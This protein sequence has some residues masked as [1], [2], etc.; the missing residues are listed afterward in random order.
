MY[1]CCFAVF[2]WNIVWSCGS[3]VHSS[4]WAANANAGQHYAARFTTKQQECFIFAS[5]IQRKHMEING[6]IWRNIFN[7]GQ[8]TEKIGK[9]CVCVTDIYKRHGSFQALGMKRPQS[10]NL[11]K[12]LTHVRNPCKRERK[13][14]ALKK[15]KSPATFASTALTF[16]QGLDFC[17]DLHSARARQLHPSRHQGSALCMQ[18]HDWGPCQQISPF[19]ED[20]GAILFQN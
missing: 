14:T 20:K 9:K 13:K 2:P 17:R 5:D 7:E 15:E 16:I 19:P 8:E 1:K 3:R 4:F 10:L 6:K 11:S 18:R 12:R